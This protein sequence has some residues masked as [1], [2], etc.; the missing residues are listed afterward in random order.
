[1]E[2]NENR[3]REIRL[4]L[5]LTQQDLADKLDEKLHK[6]NDIERGKQKIG[7]ELAEKIQ[8]KFPIDAWWLLTGKGSMHLQDDMNVADISNNHNSGIIVGNNS[9]SISVSINKDDFK[10]DS[11]DIEELISLLKYAPK[12]FILKINEKLRAFKDLAEI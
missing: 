5:G 11:A 7:V 9:G 1:M 8:E 10:D 12:S 6:I 4:F 2:K 3:I